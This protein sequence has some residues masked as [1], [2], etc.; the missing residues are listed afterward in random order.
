MR[1][2]GAIAPH[3]RGL[4]LN[5]P[6]RFQILL[7][8]IAVVVTTVAA[9][10]TLGADYRDTIGLQS[11]RNGGY[12]IANGEDVEVA[13][14]EAGP[15]VFAPDRRDAEFRNKDF[16]YYDVSSTANAHATRMGS[17]IYGNLSGIAPEVEEVHVF[18]DAT[19][20]GTRQVRGLLNPWQGKKPDKI[21]ADV[22]NNSWAGT[23][24]SYTLDVAALR[25]MDY[26]IW[27]DDVVVVSSTYNESWRPSFP[28][29]MA[30]SYNGITVGTSWGRGG[31]AAFDGGA[32]RAKPDLTAPMANTSEA[33]A[34]VSG[35]AA[36][37]LSEADARNMKPEAL[38]IKALLMAGAH[39]PSDWYRGEN[40]GGGGGTRSPLSYKY[41]AGELR[42]H[43]AFHIMAAGEQ[44]EGG[45]AGGRRGWSLDKLS[46]S[47]K[48]DYYDLKYS[49]VT[50]EFTAVLTWHRRF[51]KRGSS[52]DNLTPVL[53]DL[54]LELFRKD[55][56]KWSLFA[57]SDSAVDNVEMLAIDNLPAG[58]YRLTVGGARNEEYALA[59]D[60]DYT[61][62]PR[63]IP[64]GGGATIQGLLPIDGIVA[65]PEPSALVWSL[66]VLAIL[67]R[68]RRRRHV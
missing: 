25:R 41:G 48:D 44:K 12:L 8:A 27:R 59:W 34:V 4:N 19:F 10:P 35:A 65:A 46:G 11:L 28:S 14:V 23:F 20:V 53:A 47:G 52:Y 66:P 57:S 39:R 30:S 50:P 21:D 2:V 6:A 42:V 29:L 16:E 37:L 49:S 26:A 64:P 38:G 68:R 7:A 17:L 55:G 40:G 51:S 1:F 3:R 18:S 54:E 5:P 43:R 13:Q 22:V 33:A 9:S 56:K 60:A 45:K 58:Q 32:G 67:A 24:N 61:V 36:L 31:P 15:G 62:A 63:F